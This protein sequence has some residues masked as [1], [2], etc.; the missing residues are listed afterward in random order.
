MNNSK[1]L[2][3]AIPVAISAIT[4]G[5]FFGI[6]SLPNDNSES[7][8]QETNSDLQ[9]KD[10]LDLST[11]DSRLKE[12]STVISEAEEEFPRLK[13]DVT[14]TKTA[15]VIEKLEEDDILRKNIPA[16]YKFG[17][18]FDNDLQTGTGTSELENSDQA[19]SIRFT[20]K[21]DKEIEGISLSLLTQSSSEVIVGIQNDDG[22][23]YPS[24][25]RNN[26]EFN[27]KKVLKPGM[28]KYY[29]ELPQGFKVSK[30]KVY[31]II[32]QKSPSSNNLN[33]EDSTKNIQKEA[34]VNVINYQNDTPHQPYNPE[35]PDIYWPDSELNSL[36][37]DG[38]SWTVLNN[39]PIYILSF[40][41]GIVDGQP[42]SLMANWV[43]Q[44]NRP[45]GQIIIPHSDY[46]VEKFSFLVSK[47]G[48]PTDDL[49]YGIKDLNN[50]LLSSGIFAKSND[51]SQRPS[52]VEVSLDES[53]ELKAGKLYKFY[54]YS[55]SQKE[56]GNYNLYGH[57]FSL[58]WGAG[59]GGLIH[60]LT[61]SSDHKN[62]G[63]WYDADAVFS[64]TTR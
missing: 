23:G 58:D 42:Y 20:S 21:Y 50:N 3:I 7:V 54:I 56:V 6:T 9:T 8:N 35:D 34:R 25:T 2:K 12:S 45:V 38:S 37:H 39:W 57:E 5:V 64:I 4:V 52:V 60:R 10:T 47:E 30:D 11:K 43:I 55:S 16:N 29:F 33:S 62:W 31:H 24:V 19:H 13:G 27:V 1:T 26:E 44:E 46:K 14:V 22:N 32:I 59:Y 36:H 48:T 49:F 41:D 15:P 17:N 18:F 61:T 63:D 40:S 51:L 28:Q 53:I